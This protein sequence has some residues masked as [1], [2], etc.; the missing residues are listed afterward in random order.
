MK[1]FCRRSLAKFRP[2]NLRMS[3]RARV[4]GYTLSGLSPIIC[5]PPPR[6]HAVKHIQEDVVAIRGICIAITGLVLWS[7]RVPISLRV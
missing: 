2:T 3:M 6:D 5:I 7:D 4:A 1:P